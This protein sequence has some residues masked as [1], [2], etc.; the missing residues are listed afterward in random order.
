MGLVNYELTSASLIGLNFE[1]ARLVTVTAA[2]QVVVVADR[3][4]HIALFF[5]LVAE[6]QTRVIVLA[7]DSTW[8]NSFH[9][10][11]I[12]TIKTFIQSLTETSPRKPI[13]LACTTEFQNNALLLKTAFA[14]C[15]VYYDITWLSSVAPLPFKNTNKNKNKTEQHQQQNN[16]HNNHNA[17]TTKKILRW[18]SRE[19]TRWGYTKSRDGRH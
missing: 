5:A 19:A 1:K 15:V 9:N 10:Q 4:Y 18:R 16:N 13:S 11:K 17:K 3:F 2:S 8:V 12:S 7:C 14:A 6:W